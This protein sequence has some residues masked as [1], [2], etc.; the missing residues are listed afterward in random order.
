[1]QPLDIEQ[2]RE[3]RQNAVRNQKQ[4][5]IDIA[6]RYAQQEFALY[7]SDDDLKQLGSNIIIYAEDLNF[8]KI[9]PVKIKDLSNLDLYH[10]GWNIWNY[11]KPPGRTEPRNF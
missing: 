11:F 2:I 6:V 3:E 1:M 5:R 4:A 7:M 9:T 10:F 8:E